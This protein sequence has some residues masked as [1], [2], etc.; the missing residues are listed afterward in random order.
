MAARQAL[1]KRFGCQ[2]RAPHLNGIEGTRAFAAK[3]A[4]QGIVWLSSPIPALDGSEYN[5]FAVDAPI[6]FYQECAG[7]AARPYSSA[8][9][10]ESEC[11]VDGPCCFGEL[12]H[13]KM[14]VG[15]NTQVAGLVDLLFAH[16]IADV[17]HLRDAGGVVGVRHLGP[18]G[19]EGRQVEP[20][21]K[22]VA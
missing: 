15:E 7:E 12:L 13:S 21:L 9:L 20:E 8:A 1:R 6:R 2:K 10:R 14:A 5:F 3:T 16:V 19:K 18:S 11:L 17:L 22:A 4:A